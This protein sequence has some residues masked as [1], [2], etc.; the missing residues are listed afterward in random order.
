MATDVNHIKIDD[1][2]VS[3]AQ[4][5]MLSQFSSS[6]NIQKIIEIE[7]QRFKDL[8]DA[9]YNLAIGRR[10]ANAQGVN[11]DNIG[12]TLNIPRNGRDDENYRL[13]ILFKTYS[14]N[15]SPTRDGLYEFI[16]VLTGGYDDL[17]TFWTVYNQSSTIPTPADALARKPVDVTVY[18][19]CLGNSGIEELKEIFPLLTDLT[20][21]TKEVYETL[22][23]SYRDNSNNLIS[24]NNGRVKGLAA[25][26]NSGDVVISENCGSCVARIEDGVGIEQQYPLS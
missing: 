15:L 17:V 1:D 10:L 9:Y 3:D 20:I 22:G 19:A 12:K 23:C 26:D 13:L 6:E 11:L 14:T 8:D 7:A 24:P 2:F 21:L 25:R 18:P 5:R 4:K 16:N